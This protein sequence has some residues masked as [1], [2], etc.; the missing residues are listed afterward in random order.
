MKN[1]KI[2]LIASVLI[3]SLWL[4]GCGKSWQ[5]MSFDEAYSKLF[6]L[7]NIQTAQ[8]RDTGK[9][10]AESM[11][12]DIVA[13]TQDW[14]LLTGTLISSGAYDNLSGN[15]EIVFWFSGGVDIPEMNTNIALWTN[16]TF[17]TKDQEMF[18]YLDTFTLTP[19]TQDQ[20]LGMM[21]AFVA[22]LMNSIWK[23]WI[24]VTPRDGSGLVI[25][26]NVQIA[27]YG[28]NI[29]QFS[30]VLQKAVKTYPLLQE[31]NKTQVDGKLAYQVDR[32]PS[33]VSGFV[34]ELL[35]NSKNLGQ[36]IT[37]SDEEIN[38]IVK[39]ILETKLSGHIIVYTKDN[40]TLKLNAANT[41]QESSADIVYSTKDGAN[42]IWYAAWKEILVGTANR[43]KQKLTL[44]GSIKENGTDTTTLD[45]TFPYNGQNM[46]LI[47]TSS[48]VKAEVDISFT[49]KPLQQ[50]AQTVITESTPLQDVING[51]LW[52]LGMWWDSTAMEF[53]SDL[54]QT[55][56]ITGSSAEQ[57]PENTELPINVLN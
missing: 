25:N 20:Q 22:P 40:V 36:N 42:I 29:G 56:N 4:A 34:T 13:S 28:A 21:M 2:L 50:F 52:L 45:W 15:A 14:F 47:L 55:E 26:S 43:D 23:Q 32:N 8:N 31:V 44:K 9:P 48:G 17:L 18:L 57:L 6:S 51:V 27:P 49:V 5:D 54:M 33:G 1:K 3:L 46:K 39:D 11:K 41:Q 30:S 53:D 35:Q 7:E 38:T 24:D 10:V 16:M 12:A 19:N 37:F